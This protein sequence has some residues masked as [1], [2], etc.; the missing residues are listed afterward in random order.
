LPATHPMHETGILYEVAAVAFAAHRESRRD[1]AAWGL[2]SNQEKELGYL[3]DRGRTPSND[4]TLERNIFCKLAETTGTHR[5]AKLPLVLG[6]EDEQAGV[7]KWPEWDQSEQVKAMNAIVATKN[8]KSHAELAVAKWK[9]PQVAHDVSGK[10]EFDGAAPK[11]ALLGPLTV[12]S[13]KS[14][15]AKTTLTLSHTTTSARGYGCVPTKEIESIDA[16]GYVRYKLDCKV[17][18]DQDTVEA[19]L[20]FTELPSGFAFAKDDEV[21]AFIDIESDKSQKLKDTAPLVV[22]K[23][24]IVGT[25]RHIARVKRGGN[26]VVKFF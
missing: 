12:V 7:V 18:T 24:S 6:M 20:V 19:E 9:Y 2:F 3:Y 4:E 10:L 25:G 14:T 1:F 21:E 5:T 26:V 23:R 17:G 8:P 15:A 11:L 22:R 16:N 13:V